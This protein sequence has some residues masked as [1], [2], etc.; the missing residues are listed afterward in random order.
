MKQLTVLTYNVQAGKRIDKIVDWL[1]RLPDTDVLCLQEFP[2]DKIEECVRL[3][4]RVPYGHMFAEA[5][6]FR[7]R[8]FGE[9]TLYR[10]DRIKNAKFETVSLGINKIERR[11]LKTTV[12]RSYL[13][14]TGSISG[15]KIVVVNVHIV[16][17]AVNA[18]KFKQVMHMIEYL[19]PLRSPQVLLGDFNISS[20]LGKKRLIGLFKKSGYMMH[21]KKIATHRVGLIRH[22]FDYVFARNC[23]IVDQVAERVK[24]SDHFPI[25]VTCQFGR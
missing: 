4:G 14:L 23:M 16:A 3:L 8:I 24:F 11:I 13:I 19:L 9:F 7:K 17:L 15:R 10:T 1:N 2:K 20:I 21:P 18:V 5:F 22:Q 25:R 6:T 12:P